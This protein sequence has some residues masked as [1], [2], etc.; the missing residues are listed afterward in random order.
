MFNISILLTSCFPNVLNSFRCVDLTTVLSLG[1]SPSDR[2]IRHK[3]CS[4]DMMGR[5]ETIHLQFTLKPSLSKTV[6]FYTYHN[7]RKIIGNKTPN[8]I[9]HYTSQLMYIHEL[10]SVTHTTHTAV[11]TTTSLPTNSLSRKNLYSYIGNS[12]STI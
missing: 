5:N 7:Y 10:F 2:N 4:C 9:Y 3:S 1:P 6:K 11:T 8:L 12:R